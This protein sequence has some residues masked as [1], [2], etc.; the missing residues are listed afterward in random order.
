MRV[1]SLCL[2]VLVLSYL[3]SNFKSKDFFEQHQSV[4]DLTLKSWTGGVGMLW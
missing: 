1:L 4:F 2:L 3:N